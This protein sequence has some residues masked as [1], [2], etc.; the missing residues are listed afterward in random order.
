MTFTKNYW[1]NEEKTVQHFEEVILSL[2]QKTKHK[3]PYPKEQMSLV[4]MG[5]FKGQYN[6]ILKFSHNLANK[7][8][9]VG[10]S[11]NKADKSFISERYNI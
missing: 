7:F 3:Y 1:S 11:V 9:P 8:Q 6:K 4:I 5:R 10:I 2:S